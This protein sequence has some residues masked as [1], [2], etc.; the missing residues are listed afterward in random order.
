MTTLFINLTLIEYIAFP[1]VTIILV[2]TI[3]FFLKS[4]RSLRETMRS[5]NYSSLKT[6]EEKPVLPRR[7][8]AELEEQLAR[9]RTESHAFPKQEPAPAGKKTIVPEEHSAKDLK[10]IIANQQRMLDSYLQKV[11]ELEEQSRGAI[12]EQNDELQKE[13][14]K[15]HSVIEKKDEEIEDLFQEAKT[16]QKMAARID[17][18]YAEFEQLQEKMM[19]ME[20]QAARANNLMLELED[21]KQAYEQS[22]KEL[23]RKQEKLEEVMNE[24]HRMR[25]EMD[26]LED[27]LSEAN[28]QRQ[29]LQKKVQFL[30]ELN[31]DMQGLSETNKKLQTE[32]RRIGEL[33][34]MLTMMSEERDYL[35][36]KKR[37][38]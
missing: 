7:S 31:A 2:V 15:L 21:M 11:E 10:S 35:L 4:Q 1:I 12:R 36:R 25:Q 14:L 16:A 3:Y 34:S 22:H 33:E 18:V 27:K 38:K 19:S 17:E 23:I 37:D 9:I 13:I 29:Q 30:Q 26:T 8:V 6:K 20:K 24:N 28:L 32:L 5:T